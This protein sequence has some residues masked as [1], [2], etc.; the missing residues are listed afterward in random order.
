[1]ENVASKNILPHYQ[2]LVARQTSLQELLSASDTWP[3]GLMISDDLNHDYP[4][5]TLLGVVGFDTNKQRFVLLRVGR[6]EEEIWTDKRLSGREE[7][8]LQFV[9]AGKTN[10]QIARKL[11]IS[12]NTV[13]VHL[14]HIF[15]KLKVQS[16]TEAAMYAVRQGW[17]TVTGQTV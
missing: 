4:G 6:N 13:K 10:H 15:E 14:R 11:S 2:Q 1:M 3:S 16:R 12:E 8:I 5:L 17:V 9:I 7:E